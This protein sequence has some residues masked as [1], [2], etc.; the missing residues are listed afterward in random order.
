MRRKLRKTLLLTVKIAVGVALLGWVLNK[1][2][3]HDYVIT[4]DQTR[5]CRYLGP[6]PGRPDL[7][8]VD[9]GTFWNPREEALPAGDFKRDGDEIIHPGFATSIRNINRPLLSCAV[10]GFLVSVLIAAFRW[11]YLL[12]IQRIRIRWWEALRLTVLGQFFNTV[13]PGTVGGDVIK[14]YY[15]AKHT[16][17]KAAVLISIFVDRVMGMAELTLLAAA[18][19]AVVYLGG[20]PGAAQLRD[21]AVSVAVV[22]AVVLVT[23]ALLLSRR[24]R[25]ALHLQKLYQRLPIAHHFAA[26]GDAAVLYRKR[27]KALLQALLITFGAHVFWVGSIALLGM[28]LDIQ[29]PWY[30]YFVYIPLIYIIGAIPISVGGLGWVEGLYVY[31]FAGANASK[32]F[33]LALLARLIPIFWS[34]PGILVAVTGP[35]LPKAEQMRSELGM[36]DAPA[37]GGDAQVQP[38]NCRRE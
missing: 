16:D 22:V 11:W 38:E 3:W 5:T 32:V 20:L 29:T 33:A 14:A 24:L 28:S 18:M 17:R 4:A 21:P 27:Y 8:R 10:A 37:D 34:L 25:K 7:L 36:D 2:N 23:L 35:K 26:A 12:R 1:T 19:I 30:K 13:V 9:V 15:V 6:V 31:Y